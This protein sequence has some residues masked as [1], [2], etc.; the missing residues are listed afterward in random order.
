MS[1]HRL[2]L[3]EA[4]LAQAK[5]RRGQPISHIL[6]EDGRVAPTDML[7]AMAEASRIGQS[8]PQVVVAEAIASREDVL[9]A[10]A[11]H[12]GALV[13]RRRDSPPDPAVL[14]QLPPEFCLEHGVLPW[15]RVGDTLLLA[16]SRP[17]DFPEL[18]PLLPPDIGPVVMALALEADI[19]AEISARAGAQLAE[20]AETWVPDEDSCRDLNRMTPRTRML[21]IGAGLVCLLLLVLAPRLLFG[22]A[23]TLALGS[24]VLAQLMKLAA[25]AALP[26]SAPPVHATLPADPPLVSI[27][28]PLFREEDIAQ[29]LVKRLSRLTYPKALLDVVLVL[30]AEDQLT[31]ETLAR[32]RLPTWMRTITVPPGRIT[33]KPRALNYAYRFTRGQIVGIYDAEDAPAPDQI[34]RVVGHFDRAPREVGCLQGILDY[35][36]PRANWLSRCFTIE[37]ASWFRI[38]LPGLSRL[39][40]VVPLGGTTVFFR[41]EVLEKVCG[42][43]AHNVTEDADLG[44][45]LARHGFRTELISSVTR[46]EANNRFWPWIKQRSR[47]LKGYGITWWVHSRDPRRLWR[48]LGPKRFAGVQLLFL[49]TLVQFALA[50]VLWSFWLILMGLPHPLDPHLSRPLILGL[51]ALFLS[52]EAV[53]IVIGL[54]ALARSPHRALFAWVPTLFAYFPLGTLAIYKALWETLRNPFYWDKTQHGRSA[55]DRP[56]GDVPPEG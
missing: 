29:T 39:G 38:L 24:L 43:D 44:V 26:R 36:N 22:A 23:L 16:T 32:T 11:Q 53:S 49:T 6:M 46:E 33:T 30:E 17:D 27:L 10:Q 20:A 19:H 18:L 2:H 48:D 15:M 12:F 25:L 13:L 40:F 50:P 55:P 8:A 51:T 37:Y 35:Y 42:W 21:A 1:E 54:A 4:K 28:V 7:R 9:E 45:R 3:A 31:R 56:G 47:W 34:T 52:A 5:G 14:G 41:R